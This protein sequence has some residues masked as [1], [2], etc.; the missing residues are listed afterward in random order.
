[1][2]KVDIQCPNC[3]T[4]LKVALGGMSSGHSKK[5]HSCSATIKFEGDGGRKAERA[6]KSFEKDIRKMFR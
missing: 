2:Y 3:G 5:C 6:I 1:M 4:K